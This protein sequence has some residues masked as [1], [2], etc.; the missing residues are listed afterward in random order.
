MTKSKN[1]LENTKSQITNFKQDAILTGFYCLGF[2]NCL[3]F[4]AWN[5]V[6]VCV[7]MLGIWNLMPL[8]LERSHLGGRAG[9]RLT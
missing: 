2:E 3:Y 7:L 5:L 1:H 8:E 9:K 4:G 6:L